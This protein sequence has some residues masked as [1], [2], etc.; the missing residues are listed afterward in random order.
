MTILLVM[1]REQM[2]SSPA[3]KLDKEGSLDVT[4]QKEGCLYVGEGAALFVCSAQQRLSPGSLCL[5]FKY[6]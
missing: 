6:G 3:E 4:Q 1:M 2:V 5:R